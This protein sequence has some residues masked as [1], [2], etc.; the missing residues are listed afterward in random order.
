M[1]I[2]K[3]VIP[4]L[5]TE[6]EFLVVDTHGVQDG[7]LQ[8]MDMDPIFGDTHT[9]FI[10]FA[11]LQTRLAAAACHPGTISVGVMVPAPDLAIVEIILDEGGAAEFAA[12]DHQGVI[13]QAPLLQILHQRPRRLIGIAALGVQLGG[14]A[15]VLV[16]TGVHHLHTARATLD[17][18]PGHQAVARKGTGFQNLR[19]IHLQH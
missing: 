17:E 13:E 4:T 9:Q 14:E 12:P 18:A 19:A 16:P 8:V 1:D 6:S 2:G 11:I 5:E 7:G 15:I 3:P 10:G